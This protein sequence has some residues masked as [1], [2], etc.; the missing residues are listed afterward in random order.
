ME[1]EYYSSFVSSASPPPFC[2]AINALELQAERQEEKAALM[3]ILFL[4][5]VKIYIPS[6]KGI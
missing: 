4:P 2:K 3:V 1:E 6:L 5:S